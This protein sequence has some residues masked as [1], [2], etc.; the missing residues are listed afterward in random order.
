[1]QMSCK[2]CCLGNGNINKN[3]CIYL[4]QT[5]I[6]IVVILPYNTALFGTYYVAQVG[7]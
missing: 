2:Y 1:M 3:V 6:F 4:E 7:F 5:E